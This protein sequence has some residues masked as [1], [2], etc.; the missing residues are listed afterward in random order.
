MQVEITAGGKALQTTA[1][2]NLYRVLAEAGLLD[3]PCGGLGRCGKC[4]VRVIVNPPA[5]LPHETEL[6]SAPDLA[7]GW[8]LAC[9]HRVE[10]GLYI[11]LPLH[12]SAA[13]VHTFLGDIDTFTPDAAQ[14]YGLAVD[15]GT[16]TLAACLV[17]L[18]NGAQL[19]GSSCLNSQKSFGQDVVSRIYHA[20]NTSGGTLELQ[21]AVVEDLKAMLTEACAT[22]GLNPG[23]IAMAS[24][25][26]NPTMIHLLAGVN[27][28][29]LAHAP[30]TLVCRGP[31][32]LPARALELPMAD[33]AV[34][35]C[36]PAV[37]A[38]LGGDVVG[39]MLAAGMDK[40]GPTRM[41]IDFGTNGEI[42][43][44]QGDKLY[45]CSMAMGPALEGMNI[46]CGMRAAA[47]AI[48]DV[49]IEGETISYTTIGGGAPRGLA[50]SGLLAA[51]SALR[52]AG[53][54]DASGRLQPIKPVCERQTQRCLVI[55]EMEDIILTQGD[56][57]QVQLAKGA[58]RS[59]VE[60]L[61]ARTG[62][63][64]ESVEEVLVAG[65][66]GAHL[67]EQSLIETGLL[68][69]Q[70]AGKIRYLGNAA[71]A[72]ARLCL[73]SSAMRQR[74]ERLAGEITYIE[75]A[76]GSDYQQRFMTAMSFD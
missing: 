33:K 67:S 18:R 49:S 58:I 50:G 19:A 64:P 32:H 26:A 10:A 36:L 76:M 46:K 69:R 23:Q 47:G 5:P 41:F 59:G 2:M 73:L 27:P 11:E 34:V 16:T 53:L 43:L 60:T 13:V 21:A 6:L 45:S 14:G 65:G 28:A 71:L 52:S 74:A 56:I 54:L 29:P 1:G 68:P 61:L 51:V 15:I 22:T 24:V 3:A 17:D 39:G 20:Q 4:R 55:D 72:G 37:A 70:F 25:A 63:V 44:S 42:V 57:R 75:L 12:G 38:N 35:Y 40:Q 8:R 31:L 9:L 48:D 62:C 7:A 66:F 30:Y